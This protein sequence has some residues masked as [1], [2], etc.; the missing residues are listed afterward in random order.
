MQSAISLWQISPSVCLSHSGVLSKRMH[1]WSNAFHHLVGA[2]PSFF[3]AP[4][5]LQNFKKSRRRD[6][7]MVTKITNRKSQVADRSVSVPMTLSDLERRDATGQIFRR[8]SVN[9]AHV[10]WPTVTKFS[11]LIQVVEKLL[12]KGSSRPPSQRA[13]PQR[14][15]NFRTSYTCAY[16]VWETTTKFCILIKLD[17]RK[18]LQGR[19]GMLT[20]DVFA[21]ANLLVFLFAS[22]HY[23]LFFYRISTVSSFV[24]SSANFVRSLWNHARIFI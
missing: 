4:P 16:T 12:S 23:V 17:V 15:Q 18:I 21:V 10:V 3:R 7:P 24:L 22:T 1:I 19:P 9:Y 13:G 20:R 2:W 14:L 11:V 8:I 6:R 5:P